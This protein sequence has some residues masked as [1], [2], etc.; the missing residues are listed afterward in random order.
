MLISIHFYRYFCISTSISIRFYRF[1]RYTLIQTEKFWMVLHDTVEKKSK[2][3]L[4]PCGKKFEP[5]S[6]LDY[7]LYFE[8]VLSHF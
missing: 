6:F 3:L 7:T 2:K 5:N 8:L 1:S 4:D